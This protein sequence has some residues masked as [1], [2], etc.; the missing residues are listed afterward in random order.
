MTIIDEIT[1]TNQSEKQFV[2]SNSTSYVVNDNEKNLLMPGSNSQIS[3]RNIYLVSSHPKNKV[4]HK[5]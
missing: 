4:K 2:E 1:A 3:N 5:K